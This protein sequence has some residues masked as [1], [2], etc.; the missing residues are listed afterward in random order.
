MRTNKLNK[1]FYL[2]LPKFILLETLYFARKVII[3]RTL[4]Y[5]LE[6]Y[7]KEIIFLMKRI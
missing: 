6:E 1:R 3:M 7:Q 5:K 4:E 2:K